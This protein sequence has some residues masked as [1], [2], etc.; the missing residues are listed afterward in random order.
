MKVRRLGLA[1]APLSL[2]ASLTLS[3]QASAQCAPAAGSRIDFFIEGRNW[4]ILRVRRDA[5]EWVD[6]IVDGPLA[7]E[8]TAR[9][10]DIAAV[11]HGRN[12]DI[13]RLYAIQQYNPSPGK[14][15][16]RLVR[17][18]VIDIGQTIWSVYAIAP[19]EIGVLKGR[20]ADVHQKFCWRDGAWTKSRAVIAPRPPEF[21][22]DGSVRELPWPGGVTTRRGI[23]RKG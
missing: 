15:A 19:G 3:E 7:C 21:C 5:L 11:R 4:D 16:W 9:T 17:A 23:V 8:A 1:F 10:G 20:N 18:P 12:A 22:D 13:L 2:I 14:T 6:S